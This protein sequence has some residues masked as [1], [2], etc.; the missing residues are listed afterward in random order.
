MSKRN[1]LYKKAKQSGDFSK[2]K[3]ARNR[4][5]SKLRMAKRAYLNPKNPKRFWK[6]MK[7]LNKS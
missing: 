1:Q 4:V 7:Y 5:L 6:A 2:Y 3:F